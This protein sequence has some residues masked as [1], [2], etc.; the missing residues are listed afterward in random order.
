MNT[1]YT[2]THTGQDY[3]VSTPTVSSSHAQNDT[4]EKRIM[5][6]NQM[7]DLAL[8]LVAEVCA[9][10]CVC[11]CVLVCACWFTRFIFV[12][13]AYSRYLDLDTGNVYCSRLLPTYKISMGILSYTHISRHRVQISGYLFT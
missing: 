13:Y 7:A 6:A 5:F 3:V 9:C 12:K 2:H 10:V 8:A 11:V 4:L 1:P